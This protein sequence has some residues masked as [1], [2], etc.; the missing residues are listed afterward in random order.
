MSKETFREKVSIADALSPEEW[1]EFLRIQ[2]D[3]YFKVGAVITPVLR[4]F[5]GNPLTIELANSGYKIKL[6]RALLALGINASGFIALPV[7]K[8]GKFITESSQISPF[9]V[10][11]NQGMDGVSSA[12]KISTDFNSTLLQSL[13]KVFSFILEDG[14]EKY[15]LAKIREELRNHIA[16]DTASAVEEEM[17]LKGGSGVQKI[18]EA[19]SL[20][21]SATFLEALTFLIYFLGSREED[22]EK[23][24]SPFVQFYRMGNYPLGELKNGEYLMLMA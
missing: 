9:R 23:L 1:D 7:S 18:D 11:A 12:S 24:V 4:R 14:G 8:L 5:L 15:R 19:I 10:I 20:I 16:R 6:E 13:K 3:E 2:P 21:I 17:K 22:G